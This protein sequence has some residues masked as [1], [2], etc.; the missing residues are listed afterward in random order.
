MNFETMN[1]LVKNN[2]VR[3]LPQK[4]F[5]C[6]DHCIA[7]LKGKQQKTSHKSKEISSISLPL[8][9][10]HMDLFGPTNV[11]SIGKKSYCLVIVDDFTRFT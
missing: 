2:F 9:L 6:D 7:C 11:M 8:Q 3:G 10:L 5:S 4:E 1:K